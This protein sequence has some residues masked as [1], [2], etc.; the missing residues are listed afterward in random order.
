LSVAEK[1]I[2]E[3]QERKRRRMERESAS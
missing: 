3:D 2:I 1:L